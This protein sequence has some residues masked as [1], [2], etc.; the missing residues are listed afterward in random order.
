M[1][2]KQFI[3]NKKGVSLI[4]FAYLLPVLV[5]MFF[6]I[7]D[8]STYLKAHQ[9]LDNATYSLINMINKNLKITKQGIL[10]SIATVP[11]MIAPF[12]ADGLGVIVTCVQRETGKNDLTTVWQIAEGNLHTGSKVSKGKGY[13]A[14]LPNLAL[15]DN[16]QVIIVETFLRYQ[17]VMN[18]KY[19]LSKMGL[20]TEDIY[21]MNISRPRFGRFEFEPI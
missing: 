15:V 16:D 14:T 5:I 10:N 12:E 18:T 20:E 2:F 11:P 17:S 13:K 7:I 6:G 21:K 3:K 4:E 9:K 1:F 19:L 8:V